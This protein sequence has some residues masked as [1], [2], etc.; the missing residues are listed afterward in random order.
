MMSARKQKT[1]E[2]TIKLKFD[3]PIYRKEAIYAAWNHLESY[4]IYGSGL[5]EEPWGVAVIKVPK[6]R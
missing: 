1:H 5:P 6:R 4:D 3:R 2:I